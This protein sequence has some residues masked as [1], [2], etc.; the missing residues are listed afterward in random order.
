MSFDFSKLWERKLGQF[1]MSVY[2]FLGDPLAMYEEKFI[3][4]LTNCGSGPEKGGKRPRGLLVGEGTE[5][6][7]TVKTVLFSKGGCGLMANTK[8]SS[9]TWK[10]SEERQEAGL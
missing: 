6:E 3:A 7:A 9:V 4:G 8:T 2:L 1:G 10:K 5:A